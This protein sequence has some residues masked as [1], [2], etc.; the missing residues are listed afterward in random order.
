MTLTD[1]I[2]SIEDWQSKPANE[3]TSILN[4]ATEQ[5]TDDQLYTWAGVA[6]ITGP[7]GAEAFRVALE[8][9]GM[10]WAVHQLGGSGLQLSNPLS[11]QALLEL[12]QSGVEPLATAA[13]TLAAVGV[14]LV[15]PYKHAGLGESVT[16]Q[17]VQSA[18]LAIRKEDL[19]EVKRTA[20]EQWRV[21]I[22]E[23][24]GVGDPPVMGG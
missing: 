5:V 15:S 23:W 1:L 3:I 13:A 16:L 7:A 18:L 6:L 17:Q 24:N 10:G 12:A 22:N 11:Q 19:I 20:F 4:A 2:K 21:A 14:Q 9:N 8:A